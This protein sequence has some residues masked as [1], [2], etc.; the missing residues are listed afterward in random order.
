MTMDCR[1]YID[2]VGLWSPG[3]ADW[4]Q[5]RSVLR[6]ESAFV[7]G[8]DVLPSPAALPAAE[9]R[10]SPG[11]ARVAIQAAAEACAASGLA[12]ASLPCI[13]ASSHGDTQISDYLC[14]ELAAHSP[15]SPTKFHNSVH[16]APSGYWTIATGCMQSAT[17]LTGGENSFACGLLEAALQVEGGREPVL[18]VAYDQTAPAPL[19]SVCAITRTFGVALVLSPVA[20]ARSIAAVGLSRTDASTPPPPR[21]DPDLLA[22]REGNP[23]ARSLPLLSCLA[24]A[25]AATL[26]LPP[27]RLEVLPCT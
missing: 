24:T 6:G 10:R 11:T 20:T 22:L 3:L 12:P 19:S 26:M 27:L 13:F 23:A 5:A 1:V 2:G 7:P 16:N 8:P 14:R 17:A 18:L 9:R 15:L 4:S 25:S 21:L